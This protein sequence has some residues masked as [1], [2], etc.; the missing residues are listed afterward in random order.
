M[1]KEVTDASF[2]S[3][4]IKAEG[5]VLVDFWAPWCGPCKQLSPIIDELS[6]DM[7]EQ[8]TV[9]KCNIDE[10]PETPSKLQVRGIP[11]LMIFKNGKLVDS[12]V[13]SVPKSALYEWVRSNI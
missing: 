7:G 3:D 12:K 6:K 1:V 11:T 2:E 10:N 5:A 9:H 13:G 8:I 4:I